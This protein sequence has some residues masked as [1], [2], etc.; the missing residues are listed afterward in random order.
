M[1]RGLGCAATTSTRR[2]PLAATAAAATTD[3]RWIRQRGS[4][5]RTVQAARGAG[6]P[7]WGLACCCTVVVIVKGAEVE[8]DGGVRPRGGG[9]ALAALVLCQLGRFL[10][11]YA[12]PLVR[13]GH[14]ALGPK[15]IR[16]F[17]AAV[18]AKIGASAEPA[19][20]GGDQQRVGH[21]RPRDA[22]SV[23]VGLDLERGPR[24]HPLVRQDQFN[25]RIVGI[26]HREQLL[27]DCG[28]GVLPRRRGGRCLL[29]CHSHPHHRGDLMLI[30]PS[31]LW[32]LSPACK[33]LECPGLPFPRLPQRG[34]RL[35]RR[36]R[37]GR[38]HR[39]KSCH[40]FV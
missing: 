2:F 22:H 21:W 27:V 5:P 24:R 33:V 35:R 15:A 23:E 39:R 25:L 36:R 29:G 1:D 37:L 11:E 9:A 14:R 18:V 17:G 34:S 40:H 13:A 12:L 3:Q 32:L 10:V 30:R 4:T 26:S 19:P 31:R 16:R 38:V 6:S 7:P 28:S 8:G 20:G